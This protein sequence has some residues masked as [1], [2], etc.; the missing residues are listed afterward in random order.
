[1]SSNKA[2]VL[3]LC[4]IFAFFSTVAQIAYCQDIVNSQFVVKAGSYS[5]VEFRVSILNKGELNGSFQSTDSI[6]VYVLDENGYQIFKQ[7][8][9]AFALYNSGKTTHGKIKINLNK[10]ARYRIIFDNRHA[11]LKDRTVLAN[12]VLN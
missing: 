5:E 8:K 11:F 9:S 1:M 2:R 10:E 7:G 3:C 4:I 12:I 6:E